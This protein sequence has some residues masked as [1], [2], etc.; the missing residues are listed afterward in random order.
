ML[1]VLVQGKKEC[2]ASCLFVCYDLIRP[3][4]ALELAWMNNMIDFA[5][6]YLLQVIY[7]IIHTSI[8]FSYVGPKLMFRCF[9]SL[10]NVR[11]WARAWHRSF[12]D[13][14]LG[15]TELC[16]LTT[17]W[18]CWLNFLIIW[19]CALLVRFLVLCWVHDYVPYLHRIWWGGNGLGRRV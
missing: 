19:A 1:Y 10:S 16:F 2:F 3:D 6:P 11:Y 7:Y 13:L 4:I 15:V 12:V 18:F 8:S 17:S 14:G 5:F 9:V